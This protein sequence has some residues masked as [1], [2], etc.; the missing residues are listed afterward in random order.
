M[1]SRFP[2]HA[3]VEVGAGPVRPMVTVF[4]VLDPSSAIAVPDQR[5]DFPR[6]EDNPFDLELVCVC[7]RW[8]SD[9]PSRFPGWATGGGADRPVGGAE[10]RMAVDQDPEKSG[11]GRA[12]ERGPRSLC[13]PFANRSQQGCPEPAGGGT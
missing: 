6:H 1:T 13:G 3:V 4:S 5:L 2:S 12:S 11:F 7:A 8:R 10:L 9:H